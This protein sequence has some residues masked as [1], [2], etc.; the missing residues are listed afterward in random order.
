M[1][2]N[3]MRIHTYTG[4]YRAICMYDVITKEG[5]YFKMIITF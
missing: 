2:F 3:L 5:I 4:T 1:N